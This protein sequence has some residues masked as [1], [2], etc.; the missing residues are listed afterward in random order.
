M[1]SKES[2]LAARSNVH[3][4]L[5]PP[6]VDV[7]LQRRAHTHKKTAEALRR[8]SAAEAAAFPYLSEYPSVSPFPPPPPFT[9][10]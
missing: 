1:P 5:L 9:G 7:L 4:F 2:A 10:A 6:L 3:F 8:H